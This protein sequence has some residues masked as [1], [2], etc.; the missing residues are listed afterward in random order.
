MTIMADKSPGQ[1][2]PWKGTLAPYP[3]HYDRHFFYCYYYYFYVKE[4]IKGHE[5]NICL[6]NPEVSVERN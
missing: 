1:I 4:G 6:R 5:K 2:K 3:L